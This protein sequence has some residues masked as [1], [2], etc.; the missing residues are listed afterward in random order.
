MLSQLLGNS[1]P[2]GFIAA[3][4]EEMPLGWLLRRNGCSNFR[5]PLR[6]PTFRGSVFR[7]G[8]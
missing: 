6:Q 5:E 3:G 1:L 2:D 8:A 7:A 4:A